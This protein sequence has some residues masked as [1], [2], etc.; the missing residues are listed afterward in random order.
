MPPESGGICGRLTYD[1][2][3]GCLQGGVQQR[4]FTAWQNVLDSPE[5]GPLF[6]VFPPHPP[7]ALDRRRPHTHQPPEVNYLGRF[8][9]GDLPCRLHVFHVVFRANRYT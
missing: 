6:L 8:E 9:K 5:A 7:R 1:L 4:L 2:P 3:L